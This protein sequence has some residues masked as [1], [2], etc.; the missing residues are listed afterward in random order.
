MLYNRVKTDADFRVAGHPN[1]WAL[2]DCAAVPNATTQAISAPTAQVAVRQA[3]CL[4]WNVAQAERGGVTQPF[5]FKPVGMLASIGNYKAVGLV[6]GVRVSGFLGWFLWRG[7]YL[8]KMPTLARKI[9]IAFDWGWQLLFPR[10]IAQI[11][12]QQT[13]RLGRAHFEEGQ[14][15]FHKGDP[16]DK[17]YIIQKG[18]AGVYLDENTPPITTLK[19]GEFF[20][21]GALLRAAPRSASVRAEEPLDVLM[22][23][24][25]SF[26]QMTSH[27]DVFRGPL[28]RSVHAARSSVQLLQL[29]K[30]NPKLN[31][32]QASEVMSKPVETLP[33]RLTFD[34]ALQEARAGARGAY[35]VVD[36]HGH[37][38]GL[39]TRTDFYNAVQQLKPPQTPL[40]EVMHRPVLTVRASDT[41]TDALLLFLRHPI[42]R[43]VV[44]ADED[45]QKPVGIL[46]PFDILQTLPIQ[47]IQ[48]QEAG[49]KQPALQ[50]ADANR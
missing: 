17:F 46:T 19:P 22:I 30:D 34:E 4:A 39:V 6:F 5:A 25:D 32:V 18:S 15:V 20:G 41:L 36:E 9:Q 7:I 2:G 21:E 33:L 31:E 38:V 23:G 42:K 28:E 8:G 27:L 1:I 24:R 49:D 35:P 3:K 47:E 37:M 40:A 12:L 50:V 48:K 13:E 16:G 45:A 10:D 44:V 43:V 29:A 14:F 26:A 11:N